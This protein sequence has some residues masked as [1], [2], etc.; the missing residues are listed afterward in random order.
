MRELGIS[1]VAK[2]C[3]TKISWGWTWPKIR[4]VTLFQFQKDTFGLLLDHGSKKKSRKG[5]NCPQMRLF[6]LHKNIHLRS[7]TCGRTLSGSLSEGVLSDARQPEVRRIF[8]N[9]LW[10]CQVWNAK[11]VFSHTDDLSEILST[12]TA[13]GCK[14]C[15]SGCL[16]SLKNLSTV[17][18]WT[19][20]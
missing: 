12:S 7:V 15:T 14:R 4:C 11:G 8:F 13:Q 20:C 1:V 16:A 17:N 18:P 2:K 10:R 19:D 6:T 3:A 5:S 9:M